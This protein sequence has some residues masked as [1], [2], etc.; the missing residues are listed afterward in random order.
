MSPLLQSEFAEI[1]RHFANFIARF[2]GDEKLVPLAAALLS[3]SIRQGNICLSLG[4]A[5]L[6]PAEAGEAVLLEW[7]AAKEWRSVLANSRAV[8]RPDA[9]TPLVIDE[10]NRLYLRRYWNYQQR[11]AI[12]LRKKAADNGTRIYGK[13]GTQAEAID[14][15]V[16]NALTIISGGPGTGKTATVLHILA[17]LFQRPGNERLRVALA[18]PTGKAAARLEETVRI[19]LETLECPGEVKAR[20]P[21]SATTIH[22]LLGVKGDSVYFR[23]DRR[24]PLPFDLLVIDEASM[25]AL[26]LLS[27]LFDALPDRCHVVLLGDRDQL[28]SVEPGAVLADIVDAAA[29]PNSPLHHAVV[30]LEKNYRFSEQSGIHHLCGAVRQGDATQAMQTLRGQSYPDLVS[31]EPNEST[32]VAAKFSNAV[33]AGFSTFAAEKEPAAALARLK[34]FRVLSALRRGPFG[35]ERLN[36]NIEGILREAELIPQDV[37]SSYAGKPILISQ[38]DYQ[39]QLY[40]GDV[41]ILL[42][43]VEA[44]ENPQQLWAWFIGKENRL[45]R[46]A[47]ARLPQHEAAYA[48]TVHKSQGSEFG[49][50]LFILPDGDASVLTRELI[51]TG[52]TRARSQVEL[53]WSEAVFV[54]AVTR[55]AERDSGLRDL[56]TSPTSKIEQSRPEQLQLF[57]K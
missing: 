9:Q 31:F 39:L 3:R 34:N 36:R 22:R 44:K 16:T 25:V 1:D 57:G 33:L 8:G 13:A 37:T 47:P 4:T 5:P 11:L 2:G 35:V 28:A 38:N 42:P 54:K 46:F 21:R 10:S 52:L 32:E 51:Y 45:R 20:M 29:S 27:K 53:W 50:V 55:R 18:A 49:R 48:M 19:G 12:A 23:H 56:L 26:P 30:T 6:S 43:D 41:G 14:A 7:P 40:N 17:R 15:A 24:N